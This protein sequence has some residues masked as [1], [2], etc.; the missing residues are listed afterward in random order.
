MS[1]SDGGVAKPNLV[2]AGFEWVGLLVCRARRLPKAKQPQRDRRLE[3]QFT[4][5][6]DLPLARE[7]T[8]RP[9]S[10]PTVRLHLHSLHLSDTLSNIPSNPYTRHLLLLCCCFP[11]TAIQHI[12]SDSPSQTSPT[13]WARSQDVP[14][15]GKKVSVLFYTTATGQDMR[16]RVLRTLPPCAEQTLQLATHRLPS[17]PKPVC[18]RL[19]DYARRPAAHGQQYGVHHL[20]AG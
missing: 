2:G 1:D 3:V 14:S 4:S 20:A 11:P 10:F 8:S 7:L 9:R 18:T 12:P 6:R 5:T 19:I 16:R 17:S 15:Y 13:W